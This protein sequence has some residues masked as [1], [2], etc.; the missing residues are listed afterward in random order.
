MNINVR[1]IHFD[2]TPAINDYISKK[3]S[4]L[5]KFLY[6]DKKILCDVEIGKTTGHHK[7]GEIFRAEI[8]IR[9][10]GIKDIY[11]VAEESDLYAAI[12]V[13][14]DEAER[15]IVSSKKKRNTLFRRG[16]MKIKELLKKV[17]FKRTKWN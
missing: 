17:N 14:R 8:H 10:P 12:D 2:I 3:I 6:S 15:E 7:S 13:V 11:A 5:E 1:S 4:S 16:A 9:Q